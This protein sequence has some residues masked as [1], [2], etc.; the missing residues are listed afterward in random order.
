METSV[1]RIDTNK[2]EVTVTVDAKDVDKAIAGIYKSLAKQYRFPGFRPGHAPHAVIDSQFGREAV[3][4]QAT[5]TLVEKTEPLVRD[6]QDII[7]VGNAEYPDTSSVEP[8][9][10]FVLKIHYGVRPELK[11]SSFD[12]VEITLPA[13]E[14]TEEEIQAQLDTF[15]GYFGREED[16]EGRSV[17]AG[18][19][20]YLK[21][22]VT[23]GPEELKKALESGN[24]PYTLGKGQMPEEFDAALTG[25]KPGGEKKGVKLEL[26][27]TPEQEEAGEEKQSVTL[28]VTLN[29][30]VQRVLPELDDDFAQTKFGFDDAAAMRDA[31]SKEIAEQKKRSIEQ[32]KE[33]RVTA[34]LAKRLEGEPTQEYVDTVFQ[35]LGQNFYNQLQ[36]NNMTL[37]AWLASN[38]LQPQQFMDDLKKQAT[39]I[40]TESL[41]LDALVAEKNFDCSEE[42]VDAEFQRAGVKDWKSTK[43]Q[44]QNEGR[45]PAVRV[46]V[47]RNK[48]IDWLLETAVV[49]IGEDTPEEA[50]AKEAAADSSAKKPAAKKTSTRK[51]STGKTAAAKKTGAA[52]AADG[53]DAADAKPA[54]KKP[55][56]RKSSGTRKTAA[57]KKDDAADTAA[58]DANA[59]AAAGG[60]GA[61]PAAKKPAARKS[62]STRKTAAKKADTEAGSTE[63]A[64]E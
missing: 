41:A 59:A 14:P 22:V 4:G 35:E 2:L 23:D 36:A 56:A 46:S 55:G 63:P 26:P 57:T 25:L 54:A 37:D 34:A 44:F 27:Q 62:S 6:Q 19:Q 10:D 3:L 24:R 31:V 52:D 39:D 47:R 20:V 38:K 17:E 11:L 15:R 45:M 5:Q 42:D 13:E 7:P 48:A 49:T 8:G 28:D 51:S 58:A 29:R 61:K 1:E 50:D 53:A 18:D 33:N 32:L 30:L 21:I 40:A 16:I 9:K 43:R 60:D 64:A 12:P